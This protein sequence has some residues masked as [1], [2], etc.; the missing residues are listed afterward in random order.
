[1]K[2]AGPLSRARPRTPDPVREDQ[3]SVPIL[4]DQPCYAANRF[5][6]RAAHEREAADLA[7]FVRANARALLALGLDAPPTLPQLAA[8][9]LAAHLREGGDGR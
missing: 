9:E 4:A 6:P 2:R 3:M 5:G 7:P 8:A 1:M